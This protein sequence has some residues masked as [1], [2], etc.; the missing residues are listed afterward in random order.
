RA[1]RR[2]FRPIRPNPLMPT[3]RPIES[4]SAC[5]DTRPRKSAAYLLSSYTR[6]CR[7]RACAGSNPRLYSVLG[8]TRVFHALAAINSPD[9]RRLQRP[10]GPG[11]R[12]GC[13][14][15]PLP[16]RAAA[17]VS[18][19]AWP[20]LRRPPRVVQPGRGALYLDSR[21]VSRRGAGGPAAG[22]R[23]EEP[24]SRAEAVRVDHHDRG[25][26]P[27]EAPDSRGRRPFLLSDRLRV[28]RAP[29]LRSRAPAPVR[30][31]GRGDLAERPA[32]VHAA[33]SENAGRERTR[34]DAVLRPLSPHSPAAPA[35]PCRRR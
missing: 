20:A 1:A 23:A 21:G 8:N 9:V 33:R 6:D 14:L 5:S 24:V 11:P 15:V 27:G 29:G 10:A 13:A 22:R 30:A 7:W 17:E 34:L 28:G 18:R 4:A 2:M 3:F 31:D 35:R 12:R 16:G 32:R 26:A 25:A 19:R